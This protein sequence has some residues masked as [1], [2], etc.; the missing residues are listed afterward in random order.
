[1]IGK[2]GYVGSHLSKLL[3]SLWVHVAP[4]SVLYIVFIFRAM[5][6]AVVIK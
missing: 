4:S 6:D 3:A 2:E 5:A 1:M